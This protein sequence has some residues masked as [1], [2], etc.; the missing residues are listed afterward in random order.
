MHA[1][2]VRPFLCVPYVVMCVVCRWCG[3]V[4]VVYVSGSVASASET[5]Y[6]VH[7]R[8]GEPRHV[9]TGWHPHA[10]T[11]G[12]EAQQRMQHRMLI[13]ERACAYC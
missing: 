8:T 12:R 5:G 1:C 9:H 11:K 3:C 2:M 7:I 4:R 6:T 10:R 13:H